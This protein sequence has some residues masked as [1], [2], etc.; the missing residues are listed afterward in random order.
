VTGTGKFTAAFDAV[1]AS[2]DV[3]VVKIPPQ[4]PQATCDAE[5]FVRSVRE[6]CTDRLLI[7]H[8]RHAR[9]V[10]HHYER[11]FNNHRPHQSL[12][13]HPPHHDP[14]TVIPLNAPIRRHRVLGG[15]INEHR[16]AA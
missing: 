4:T 8:E 3:E 5:R 10:V 6:E 7:Y 15:V 11:H 14:A 9:T 12:N 13:Q 16:R 2:G 1:F